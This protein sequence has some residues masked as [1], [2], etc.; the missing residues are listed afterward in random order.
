VILGPSLYVV[1]LCA[2]R[3]DALSAAKTAAKNRSLSFAKAF[4][5]DRMEAYLGLDPITNKY[6]EYISRT[7]VSHKEGEI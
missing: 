5:L 2:D 3:C 1:P 7:D 6:T 4:L